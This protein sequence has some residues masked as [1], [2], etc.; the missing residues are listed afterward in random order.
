MEVPQKPF[1]GYKWRWATLTPTES[2]NQ[3][4]V[5]L[6][7]LRVFRKHEHNPPSS[8]DL[9]PDLER[10]KHDTKVGVDLVRTP[11]RNIIRNSGQYWISLG[12]LESSTHGT[13][14]LT[15]FGRSVAEGVITQVE[16]A[17]TVVKTLELPNRRIQTD[18]SDWDAANLS[19]RPLE[20]ILQILSRLYSEYGPDNAFIT[21][22]ELVEIIIPLAGAQAPIAIHVEALILQRNGKLNVSAWPDCAPAANDKRMAREFLLFLSCYGF[23][24][25][26][27]KGQNPLDR[28]Y[29]GA[30]SPD[31][32]LE[33]SATEIGDQSL[34]EIV[35]TFRASNVPSE[36]ARKRVLR[37]VLDRPGQPAF[38][39]IVLGA[40]HST[41]LLTGVNIEAVL[42]AAHIVP[43]SEKGNDEIDNGL[44]LRSD[45]HLLFDRG[46]LC[47]R[48]DGKVLLSKAAALDCNYADISKEVLIPEF[49]NSE[50]LEWRL[51]YH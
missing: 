40:Y 31:L 20:L 7:L 11:E 35:D 8:P 23:C 17:T 1:P 10:V 16:F 15:N 25:R 19:I 38:R 22:K 45:I 44:C 47:L 51:N 46:H 36:I 43:I 28:Y 32:I 4:S 24:K 50:Y 3:P 13:I 2:L 21:P 14:E 9:I 37:E 12:L 6:G 18:V 5:Y 41:C 39:K 48:P 33:I 29:L 27:E 49:I 26:I 42:E 30:V 34:T